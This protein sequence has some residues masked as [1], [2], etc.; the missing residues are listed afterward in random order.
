MSKSTMN[1]PILC[2]A[3]LAIFL[4][5]CSD[6]S[7]QAPITSSV[8]S[9][10][11]IA[12]TMTLISKSTQSEL[13]PELTP[14]ATL[15]PQ[16][17]PAATPQPVLTATLTPVP[18]A[19][20]QPVL[21]ATPTPVPTATPTPVPTATPTPVPTA[22]PTQTPTATPTP[23]PAR[24]TVVA[25]TPKAVDLGAL[26]LTEQLTAEVRDQYANVMTGSPVAWATS[27]GSVATVDAA[28]VVTAT[29]NGMATVTAS[30]GS[31]SIAVV[32][33][34]TQVVTSVEVTPSVVELTV[35]A[36]PVQLMAEGFDANGHTVQEAAFTW[37]SADVLVAIVDAS[38]LVTA[39]ASG[40]AA[41]T[42]AAGGA[43]GSA[44]VTVWEPTFTLSG[45]V[46]DA[47]RNG[48]PLAGVKVRL[49]NG[50]QQS[51]TTDDNGSYR[52]SNVSGTVTVTAAA[53]PNYVTET[54]EVTLS[55]D[56][57]VDF[58][59]KHRGVPPYDGTVYVTPNIL[60]PDDPTSL[61]TVT[62]VGRGLRE[63][64]DRRPDKW[65]TVNA[66]LF[67]VRYDGTVLEFQVNPEF[68]S[69]EAARMEVDTYAAALGR[70]PAVFLSRAQKV[71]INA[72]HELFGGNWQDRS[73][74]IHTGEGRAHIRDGYLEEVFVHEG[75]HI[76]LDEHHKNTNR[77]REAQKAD[78]VFISEYA[79]DFPRREDLAE[80]ILPYFAL[81][82]LP[83]RLTASDRAAIL[84]A[85]PNRL[86][87]FDEQELD[88]S[89]Y[90]RREGQP[91][92]DEEDPSGEDSAN[93][94][95]SEFSVSGSVLGPDGGPL[96]RI[97]IWVWQGEREN[98]RFRITEP[99]GTFYV[100]VPR[101]SFTLDVYTDSLDTDC[102]F[103]GWYDGAG[104]LATERRLAATVVV[105]DADV[106][107]IEIRLP[108]YPDQLPFIEWCS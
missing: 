32:V 70:L 76:S 23:E 59:L 16:P 27:D 54:V 87:Y 51:V 9:T 95:P 37:K 45:T 91:P 7:N 10:T 34:V 89:P 99:D 24:A 55:A 50:Q 18:T 30:A 108:D 80:S 73:F 42:A 67:S 56:R 60:G 104:G 68:G 81:R 101:G 17:I 96:G 57:T 71:Q 12:P 82:F 44:T 86:A 78:G 107:G 49:K 85:I 61:Q 98:S 19:T 63:I 58:S 105:V 13:E 66:Y 15:T 46:S 72:G 31:A 35:P 33:T 39:V 47:R 93:G 1:L 4:V 64:Y 14:T 11:T 20:P 38:G 62:Y 74:L 100:T 29:G 103:V 5:G 88:M 102:T 28:G 77:W 83:E 2:I 25:V 94:V 52:F 69:E 40:S 43:S 22:T 21:T 84:A 90:V 65:I 6:E 75:A 36:D 48:Q 3:L 41:V 26:G 97:G 8:I 106:E 53:R 92:L 79:R